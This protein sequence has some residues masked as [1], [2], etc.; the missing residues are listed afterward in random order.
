MVNYVRK[1]NKSRGGAT[2][3]PG[4]RLIESEEEEEEEEEEIDEWTD[5]PTNGRTDRPTD[6]RT[7]PL[8]EKRGR[9]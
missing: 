7:H 6:L 8:I 2:M 1:E 4:S 5:R 3:R 9:I